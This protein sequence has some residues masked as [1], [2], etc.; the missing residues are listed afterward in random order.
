MCVCV[1]VCVP[2]ILCK[3]N[4][5]L[6]HR[7]GLLNHT[8]TKGKLATHTYRT[9]PNFCST[10]LLQIDRAFLILRMCISLY[11][12][13]YM[14]SISVLKQYGLKW[15]PSELCEGLE[16]EWLSKDAGLCH[17]CSVYLC[18]CNLSRPDH[19]NFLCLPT[20]GKC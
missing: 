9:D 11:K 16:L 10:N 7:P 4:H 14:H 5:L 20:A 15:E 17:L 13:K 19:S 1:C 8:N 12:I 3:Q 18:I 6:A 2:I